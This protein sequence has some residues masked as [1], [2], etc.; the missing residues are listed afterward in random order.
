MGMAT[1][2]ME[3]DTPLAVANLMASGG[4]P[5]LTPRLARRLLT[6]GLLPLAGVGG[7][8]GNGTDGVYKLCETTERHSNDQESLHVPFEKQE[9][10]K[11]KESPLE[12]SPENKKKE[13]ATKAE[14]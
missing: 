4:P 2:A 10:L 1:A 5:P 14:N 12:V 9:N 3:I 11:G 7:G 8:S 6:D 13:A